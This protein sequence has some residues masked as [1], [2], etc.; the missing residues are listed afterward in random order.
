MLSAVLKVR[1]HVP[2]FREVTMTVVDMLLLGVSLLTLAAAL[3]F[4]KECRLV[5]WESLRH[6]LV[7]SVIKRAPDG[8]LTVLRQ[9]KG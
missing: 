6:P 9:S 2:C 5:V 3:L 8:S 4:S 1:R 7:K